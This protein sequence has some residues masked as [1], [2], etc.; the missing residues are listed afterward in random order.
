MKEVCLRAIG[1]SNDEAHLGVRIWT[2]LPSVIP[3]VG[4]CVYLRVL[5]SICKVLSSIFVKLRSIKQI[6]SSWSKASTVFVDA[7]AN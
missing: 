2:L 3:P 6:S 1:G 7:A 5:W 4:R